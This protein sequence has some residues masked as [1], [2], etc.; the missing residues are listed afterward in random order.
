MNNVERWKQRARGLKKETYVLYLAVRDPRMPWYAK[1]LAICVVGYA[2]SPIDLI[3]DFVPVLGYLDD[4]VL[5]PL[6][7]AL[8]LKMIPKE[9]MAECREKAQAVMAQGKP[10]NWVAAGVIIA[11][12]FLLAALFVVLV[13]R[14]VTAKAMSV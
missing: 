8:V 2:F 6:G 14:I 1:L 9:V 4:L 7:I 5:V 13:I 12:W 10:T 11:V 3:P